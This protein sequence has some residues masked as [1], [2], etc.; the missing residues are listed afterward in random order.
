MKDK[1]DIS[2]YGN[3]KNVAIQHYLLNM[4]HRILTAVDTNTQKE[5]FAV[6]ASMIDWK[7]AFSRQCHKSGIESFIQNNVRNSL[8]PLLVNYFQDPQMVV[9][10]HGCWSVPQ[11]LNGGGPEGA[12][13]GIIEYLLQSNLNAEWVGPDDRYKFVDDLTVL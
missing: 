12:T 13:L 6:I 7:Q 5:T 8:V 4:I 3:Q 10:H 2:Q 9:K 11:L 1:M